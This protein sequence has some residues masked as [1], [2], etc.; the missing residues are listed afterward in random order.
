MIN[1]RDTLEA[2]ARGLVC[3]LPLLSRECNEDIKELLDREGLYTKYEFFYSLRNIL[4]TYALDMGLAGKLMDIM[5]DEYRHEGF[6]LPAIR[7][8]TEEVAFGYIT[9]TYAY[10]NEF[11]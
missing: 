8:A 11:R 2:A 7:K 5:S 1:N 3:S 10:R 9:G 6:A 4:R